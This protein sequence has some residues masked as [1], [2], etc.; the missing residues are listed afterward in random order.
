[1]I[2]TV[3]L[4]HNIVNMIHHETMTVVHDR[5]MSTENVC[6]YSIHTISML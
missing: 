2:K 4:S 3:Q 5:G 6:I 1:M